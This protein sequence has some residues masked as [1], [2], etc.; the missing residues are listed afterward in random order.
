MYLTLIFETKVLIYQQNKFPPLNTSTTR[1]DS[2][3]SPP[4]LLYY[5]YIRKD[6]TEEGRYNYLK[7][8]QLFQAIEAQRRGTVVRL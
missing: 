5:G 4:T 7:S 1:L 3:F 6:K 8:K 2:S